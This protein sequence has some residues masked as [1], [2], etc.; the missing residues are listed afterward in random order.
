MLPYLTYITFCV[1]RFDEGK[2]T[3][4]SYDEGALSLAVKN[5]KIP[6]LRIYESDKRK[7]YENPD[8]FISACIS[9]AKRGG[10]KG[11]TL[12]LE[13]ESSPD[14]VAEFLMKM[15]KE[16]LGCDLIL[17]C[18]VGECERY[19]F[20]DY[21]DGSVVC[22]PKYAMKNK[23]SFEE[24]ERR[25]F[26]DFASR[27]ESAKSFIDLPTLAVSDG[28]FHTIDSVIREA[29]AHSAAIVHDD[30]LRLASVELSDGRYT[31]SPLSN[32]K[33]ILDAVYEYGYMGISFDIMRIPMPYLYAYGAMFSTMAYSG[34]V[35]H[36]SCREA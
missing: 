25:F 13:N 16:L 12:N 30:E 27:A 21:S 3:L 9:S 29:R 36:S 34:I 33:A 20:T 4:L 6:L 22:Y 8:T 31:Y 15:R 26:S 11:I 17:L 28:G 24:G 23:K 35:E 2:I 1:A 18:E 5:G 32:I 10:F 7:K 14:R 19:D